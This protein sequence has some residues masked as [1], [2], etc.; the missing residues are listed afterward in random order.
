[1]S[2]EDVPTGPG[3]FDVDATTVA[4]IWSPLGIPTVSIPNSYMPEDVEGLYL[5]GPD[6]RLAGLVTW[7]IEGDSAEI[8]T[9]DAFPTSQGFGRQLLSEAER[10]LAEKGVKRFWLLTSNDNYQGL[11]F[12]QR[13]GYRLINVHLNAMDRVREIKPHVPLLGKADIPLTDLWELE[14]LR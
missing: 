4:E 9:L 8:V 11:G 5:N 6:G 10:Q 3:F 7:V 14:K 12:Y 2:Q 13:Q 1:M